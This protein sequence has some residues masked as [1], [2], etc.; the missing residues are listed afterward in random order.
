[1]N[2]APSTAAR[3][4]RRV[5]TGGSTLAAVFTA[6][7]GLLFLLIFWPLGAA[8]LILACFVGARHQRAAY[9]S[10]CGNGVASTSC[11]CPTCHANLA[12]PAL[13][14]TQADQRKATALFLAVAL[15]ILALVIWI[16]IRMKAA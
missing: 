15:P 7:L 10:A 2:A 4:S 12:E 14:V 6:G 8:L 16:M 3:L 9:C 13:I 11:L 1:M 5:K